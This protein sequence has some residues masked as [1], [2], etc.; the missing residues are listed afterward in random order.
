MTRPRPEQYCLHVAQ[1]TLLLIAVLQLANPSHADVNT[2]NTIPQSCSVV[3]KLFGAGVGNLDSYGSAILISEQ[4]HVITVWNHLINSGYLTAVTS[5][6]RRFQLDVIGTSAAHDLAVLKLQGD[7]NQRF[8]FINRSGTAKPASGT[9]VRAFSNMFHVATGNESVSVV[10]GI[11]AAEVKLTAGFGRWKLPL[12]SPVL[13]L[14]AI[15]NNSGAA[16]GLLADAAGTPIGLLGRELR[17]DDSGTWVNYAVPFETLNPIIDTILSGQSV[18]R[19]TTTS[20]TPTISDR[21]LTSVWGLTLLPEILKETPA[22]ID[23]VVPQSVAAEA[24]LR[25]GDLVVLVN[26]DAIQTSR[27]LRR[28]LAV[29]RSG[30]EITITVDRNGVLKAIQMRVP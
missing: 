16:G 26:S 19:G 24:G 6:G 4:G 7:D 14:D 21:Q 28:R 25:R 1:V 30:L 13:I 10:H 12:Q 5:D 27:E 29:I 22:Y 15:T 23:R 3:V 9:E 11:I 18:D 8:P 2:T 17:H 20:K